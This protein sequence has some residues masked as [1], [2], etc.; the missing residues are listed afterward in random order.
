MV[1]TIEDDVFTVQHRAINDIHGT[2]DRPSV[3]DTMC[4]F[5]LDSSS[6]TSDISMDD[7]D[8]DDDDDDD[9]LSDFYFDSRGSHHRGNHEVVDIPAACEKLEE[10]DSTSILEFVA[11]I[12]RFGILDIDDVTPATNTNTVSFPAF[13]T[14]TLQANDDDDD[15][16]DDGLFMPPAT[17]TRGRPRTH[18]VI[19]DPTDLPEDR[20]ISV[21]NIGA[22]R[23][24]M[25]MDNH[26]T[27]FR[28]TQPAGSGGLRQIRRSWFRHR[29]CVWRVFR[30]RGGNGD[31]RSTFYANRSFSGYL[32]D[33]EKTV[34]SCVDAV[35]NE[36]LDDGRVMSF[37]SR[38]LKMLGI[39]H[40]PVPLVRRTGRVIM[41]CL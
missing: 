5:D 25:M 36:E 35:E 38:V 15:D 18:A 40:K 12:N 28:Q 41:R 3:V 6:V 20:G 7:I 9:K 21:W 2:M 30:H 11:L 16:D 8:W 39:V 37:G 4:S 10:E 26:P 33:D 14:H 34:D 24:V 23:G 1:G 27:I 13:D 29:L 19:F 22:V 31:P 17:V 32:A